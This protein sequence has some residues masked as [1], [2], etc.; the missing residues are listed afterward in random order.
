[1]DQN[2]IEAKVPP[3]A[4]D[5]RRVLR[6]EYR[7]CRIVQTVCKLFLLLPYSNEINLDSISDLFFKE[8]AFEDKTLA[9]TLAGRPTDVYD[10]RS[11]TRNHVSERNDEARQF[12]SELER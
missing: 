12:A 9:V 6:F 8:S 1:M 3:A 4:H 2:P 10:V 7:L 11:T 5:L